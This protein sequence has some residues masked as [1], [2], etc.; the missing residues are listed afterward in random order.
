[1]KKVLAVLLV[2]MLIGLVGC[3][4]KQNVV[5][6]IS[7]QGSITGTITG[8]EGGPVPGSDGLPIKVLVIE[9]DPSSPSFDPEGIEPV[10]ETT[11][12]GSAD[13]AYMIE[14][15]PAGTY[16]V[17]AW[18]D[19]NGS[20]ELE[21]NEAGD[22]IDAA[23][24]FE[25]NEGLAPVTVIANET[26]T[27]I[28]IELVSYAVASG[29]SGTVEQY[30]NSVEI[31]GVEVTIYGSAGVELVA[32]TSNTSGY[33]EFIDMP[34]GEYYLKATHPDYLN[35]LTFNSYVSGIIDDYD[36]TMITQSEAEGF[37]HTNPA[38]GMVG[39]VLNNNSGNL[40]AGA[41]VE[42]VD[43]G[44]NPVGDVGYM[45]NGEIDYAAISTDDSGIFAI[46]DVPPGTYTLRVT[47][48]Y[49]FPET[50]VHVEADSLTSG[51]ISPEGL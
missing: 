7:G 39:G 24:A 1:M 18:K 41:T 27:G 5:D 26:L 19:I 25:G 16:Y 13:V 32:V 8:E 22:P 35:S 29:I 49:T 36:I 50:T 31:A 11:V 30:S 45:I 10:A 21:F 42:L 9:E 48:S 17:V 20:G 4:R 46:K 37:G 2:I 44:G 12:T 34:A 51:G 14:G 47:G 3:A 28:D 6:N 33:Y 43:S 15:V 23:G 40:L 38:M